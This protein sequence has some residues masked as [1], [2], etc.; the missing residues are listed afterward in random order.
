MSWQMTCMVTVHIRFICYNYSTRVCKS[1][2]CIIVEKYPVLSSSADEKPA[3][4]GVKWDV[5][6]CKKHIRP[7]KNEIFRREEV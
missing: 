5:R 2:E 4:Y 6:L 7:A 3:Q 1:I